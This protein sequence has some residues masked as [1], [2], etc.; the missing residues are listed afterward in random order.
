MRIFKPIAITLLV[1]SVLAVIGYLTRRQ[2]LKKV[3]PEIE[4]VE[5]S[6][7]TVI[8]DSA[9]V[10]MLVML[11]NKSWT[12]YELNYADITLANDSLVL[13]HYV[14]DSV[15]KLEVNQVRVFPISFTVPIK[16]AIRRIRSLQDRDST[17]IS[18]KGWV[19]FTTMFG[20]SKREFEKEIAVEVPT[21]PKIKLG[22]L[23]YLGE[24][25]GDQ[26]Y[27]SFRMKVKVVNLNK[28][29]FW[30]KD[31]SYNMEAGKQIKSVGKIPGDI[32]ILPMDSVYME[33]PFR[34]TV[35]KELALFF[36][37][38]FNNDIVTYHL[39]ITGTVVSVA[40]LQQDIPA[41]FNTSGQV[42]L[43]NPDRKKIKITV[44]KNKKK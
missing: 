35:D 5:I 32:R 28:K 30:F 17:M 20:Q 13:V 23:E 33:V 1:L 6:N 37:I 9:Y 27:Y 22:E 26:N 16:D 36:K 18:V 8:D 34:V 25:K 11:R 19:N 2:L 15:Q 39:N 14:N 42:E 24:E 40:G 38:L 43:Y 44:H 10:K 4:Q 41:T 7:I 12:S 31:V 21:P 29:E 3:L